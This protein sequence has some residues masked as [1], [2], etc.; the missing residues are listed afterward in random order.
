MKSRM[1]AY[2]WLDLMHKECNNGKLVSAENIKL[3]SKYC[4]RACKT[5]HIYIPYKNES[6]IAQ[7][8]KKRIPTAMNK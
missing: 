3:F 4:A 5:T 6:E 1:E 8:V 7:D 2:H